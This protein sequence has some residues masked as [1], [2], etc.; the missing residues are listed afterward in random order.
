MPRQLCQPQGHWGR[1]TVQM[2]SWT[3]LLALPSGPLLPSHSS[4]TAC[5][6]AR[7]A[8]DVRKLHRCTHLL[9]AN[10]VSFL[11]ASNCMTLNLRR[12]SKVSRELALNVS[13]LHKKYGWL[14]TSAPDRNSGM[15]HCITACS[16]SKLS[17]ANV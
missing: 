8:P 1:P 2:Q 7:P 9:W 5:R 13:S 16:S 12:K 3:S 10:L 15:A 14:C 11:Q 17:D 6:Q 4:A